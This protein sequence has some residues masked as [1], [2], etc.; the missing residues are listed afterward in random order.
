MEQI[1]ISSKK[2]IHI[3]LKDPTFS[4]VEIYML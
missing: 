2:N 4:A 3:K 1:G